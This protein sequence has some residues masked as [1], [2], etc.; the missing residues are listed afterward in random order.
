MCKTG[1]VTKDQQSG[2]D[3]VD[4]VALRILIQQDN[5]ICRVTIDNQIQTVY[6][7]LK[8]YGGLS[9]SAPQKGECGLAVDI[10]YIPNISTGN[11]T[12]AIE[13]TKNVD[14]RNIPLYQNTTLQ[15]KSIIING[16]FTRGYCM[17]IQRGKEALEHPYNY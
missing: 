16:T 6:T 13:C 9:L 1:F 14:H 8:K 12:D 4:S 7:G 17:Q 11:Q 5:C 15:F 10:H 2:S 3:I